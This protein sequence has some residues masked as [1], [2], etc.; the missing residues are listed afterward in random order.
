MSSV[1]YEYVEVFAGPYNQ[2]KLGHADCVAQ[3]FGKAM[4][5]W[6]HQLRFGWANGDAW[7]TDWRDASFG[8]DDG[9][10]DGGADSVDFACL[11]THSIL[12]LVNYFQA[13]FGVEHARWEWDNRQ[14]RLGNRQL[15]WLYLD[16][17]ESLK[18]PAP[19]NQWHHAFHGL[20]MIFGFASGASDGW[21]PC[22][23]GG[24]FGW[25]AGLGDRLSNAWMDEGHS[26]WCDDVPVAMAC[27]RSQA[28]AIDRVFNEGIDSGYDSIPHNQITWYAWRWRT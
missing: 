23:R 3:D 25:R 27:G 11:A 19:Q 13:V 15:K 10:T 14:A 24:S 1:G 2:A 17:C 6:G 8:G 18:L 5:S 7:E 12:G 20:H 21:P 28:D 22:G 16:C 26:M 4:R 9:N